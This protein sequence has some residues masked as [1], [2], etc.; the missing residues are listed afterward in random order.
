MMF[1]LLEAVPKVSRAAKRRA[2]K[3]ED[4]RKREEELKK[5]REFQMLNSP[6]AIEMRAMAKLFDERNLNVIDICPDGN[7]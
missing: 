3:E 2:K 6:R 7:W 5:E 4:A 1:N